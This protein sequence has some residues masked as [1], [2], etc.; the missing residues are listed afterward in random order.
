M[1]LTKRTR[2]IEML[3][4]CEIQD[5]KAVLI[6]VTDGHRIGGVAVDHDLLKSTEKVD[7]VAYLM[8]KLE[9]T[10]EDIEETVELSDE[11]RF[12]MNRIA[13]GRIF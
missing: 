13:K 12:M 10:L 5:P 7:L 11:N 2:I 1:K 3:D 9:V 4:L 8:K 6:L